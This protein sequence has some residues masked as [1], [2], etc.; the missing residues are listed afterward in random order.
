[1]TPWRCLN[2]AVCLLALS[3]GCEGLVEFETVEVRLQGELEAEVSVRASVK[4]AFVRV[5]FS[6]KT[7]I[8][9]SYAFGRTTTAPCQ[10]PANQA[11]QGGN[12]V[13]LS[14]EKV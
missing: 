1:M 5:K 10:L 2:V 12:A 3:S 8:R 14:V 6:F 9:A 7:S 13:A 11:A 4:I